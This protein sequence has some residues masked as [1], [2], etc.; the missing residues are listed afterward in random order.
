VTMTALAFDKLY[1][2][3]YSWLVDTALASVVPFVV[4]LVLNVSLVREDIS[5]VREA[6]VWYVKTS[7]WYVK[8][9]SG[10]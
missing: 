3:L 8:R 6:S 1:Q 10:T 7:V 2:R 4:L 5:L 9:Q